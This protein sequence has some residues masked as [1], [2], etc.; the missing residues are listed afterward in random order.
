[1]EII[2]KS[3][4]YLAGKGVESARLQSESILAHVLQLPRMQLYLDFQRE[5]GE[6]TV[7]LCRELVRRRGN[8]E[9]L[10]H[11]LGSVSFCGLEIR[12][13]PHALI[14][15]PETEQLVEL[16]DV[17][18]R[19]LDTASPQVLDFGT[20]TGCI[21]LAVA[22]QCLTARIC[23]CDVSAEALNL[24]RTNALSLRLH[25][26]ITLFHGDGFS[27]LP[28]DTCFD[29]IVSNPP[30]IPGAEVET[31]QP[32]VSQHDPRLAL[33]G[34]SDGLDFYRLLATRAAQYLHPQG[35]LMVE[36]GDGQSSAIAE[37]LTGE[38][39]IVEPSI[40][41]YSGRER[42]L[43]ARLSDEKARI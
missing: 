33:D 3:T 30:Y 15:R 32:E 39:W 18:L 22:S 28:A 19:A 35:R 17:F 21:A 9:P 31:L 11:L 27:A 1:L 4:A 40:A 24:A 41:D 12:V 16:A 13:N 25:E 7:A 29:L 42:F 14:P 5:L 38:K 6:P 8:R 26:R 20:G 2:Q 36:H 34:G 43:I 23:A 37:L 10:Q